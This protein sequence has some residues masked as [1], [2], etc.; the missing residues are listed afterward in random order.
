MWSMIQ[1][2]REQMSKK[3]RK[4]KLLQVAKKGAYALNQILPVYKDKRKVEKYKL[5]LLSQE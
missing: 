3:N 1:T 5:K 2:K 4:V